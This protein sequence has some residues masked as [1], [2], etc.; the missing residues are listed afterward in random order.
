MAAVGRRRKSKRKGEADPAKVRPAYET[1]HVS[2]EEVIS[3]AEYTQ[4]ELPP[5]VVPPPSQ[6]RILDLMVERI[7]KADKEM[8]KRE[9]EIIEEAMYSA[10]QEPVRMKF[11]VKDLEHMLGRLQD[12]DIPGMSRIDMAAF[13]EIVCELIERRKREMKPNISDS[14]YK[15]WR[16]SPAS[17]QSQA[18]LEERNRRTNEQMQKMVQ[19]LQQ[20]HQ[21]PSPPQMPFPFDPSTF[22]YRGQRPVA[23]WEGDP[24][25]DVLR[26]RAPD[27]EILYTMSGLEQIQYPDIVE[28]KRTIADELLR[29]WI[30]KQMKDMSMSQRYVSA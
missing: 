29:R 21:Q 6:T 16:N 19:S 1:L 25:A 30:Y 12:E 7:R 27:G 14:S 2:A 28:K 13:G 8:R 24:Q 11:T 4:V 9:R 22:R 23:V 15:F 3:A 5:V 17:Q 10:P 20:Y 18:E 26:L